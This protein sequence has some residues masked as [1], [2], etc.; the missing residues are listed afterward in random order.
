MSLLQHLTKNFL[1]EIIHTTK[2]VNY[3]PSLKHAFNIGR[4]GKHGLTNLAYDG[5]GY[6]TEINNLLLSNI[7]KNFSFEFD[8]IECHYTQKYFWLGPDFVGDISS[9]SNSWHSFLKCYKGTDETIIDPTYKS[10]FMIHRGKVAKWDS[11]YA[12][13]IYKLPPV[14]VGTQNELNGLNKTMTEMRKHDELH[15]DDDIVDWHSNSKVIWKFE[16]NT[17]DLL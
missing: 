1:N 16:R 6:S 4:M 11:F 7:Q 15:K 5:R 12:E 9:Q 2:N 13:A 17:L 8:R 3:Q 14:F 10:L